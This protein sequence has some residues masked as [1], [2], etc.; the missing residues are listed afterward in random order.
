MAWR[1]GPILPN[2]PAELK[3]GIFAGT[4]YPAWV[5]FS[6]DTLPTLNDY[7]STVGIGIKLFNTPTPKIFGDPSDTTFDFIMQNVEVFFVDTAADMCAFTK[8]GVVDGD[9]GPYLAAHPETAKLLNAMAKPVGSTLSIDYWSCLPFSLGPK[10][11]VKYKLEPTTADA[12]P[13]S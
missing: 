8:A 6:S 1:T 12:P 13:A 4:D 7:K 2:L 9:Y 5:R 11:F 10:Q 3:V